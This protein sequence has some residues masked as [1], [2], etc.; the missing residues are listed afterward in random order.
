MKRLVVALTALLVAAAPSLADQTCVEVRFTPAAAKMQIVVW[1]EDASGKVL[2]TPFITRTTGQFGLANRPG[3]A[4]LKTAFGWPYGRREMVA[5]V[6]AHRRDHHYPKVMMGGQCGNGP[7]ATC[8]GA[9]MCASCDPVLDQFSGGCCCGDCN[10]NTIAYHSR[11][12]SGE[13]FYCPPDS[14][15]DAVSCASTFT[16]SKGAYATDGS[17]SL[18]PPRADLKQIIPAVDSPDV[19][20]FAKQNDLVAVSAATPPAMVPLTPPVQWAPNAL[21]PGD[22]AALIEAS[23][24]SDFNDAHN[25][26]NLADQQAAWNFEG[27]RFL[28]QPSIVWKVPFHWDG[29]TGTSATTGAYEGYGDWDGATGTLHPP[30]GTITVDKPGSGAGRLLAV[31]DGTSSWFAKVLVAMA[32]PVAPDPVGALTLTPDQTSIAVSFVA[33]STGAP[34]SRFAVRYRPGTTPIT[35]AEFDSLNAGPDASGTPGSTVTATITPLDRATDYVVA[36]RAVAA[37]GPASK[38]VFGTTRTLQPKFVTLHGCFVA[39]AAFGSPLEAHVASLRAFRDRH[40]LTN[41]AGRLATAIY[42]ALSPPLANAIASDE[43]LRALARRA[44]EPLVSI[45][46]K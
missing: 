11:V 20:D 44:L 6:W 36:V 35:D 39:T 14:G 2:A 29:A 22:Y 31:S 24:E 10:D 12:S 46:T 41:P 34:A 13:P 42:Y 21:P 19:L 45:V 3:N 32:N 38:L 8:P 1:I 27:H 7:L 9:A 16:G 17:Y 43:A 25:H 5:P 40:L 18:Y 33:P 4:L 15:P 30:D 28:G 23:Q 26:D 37:C